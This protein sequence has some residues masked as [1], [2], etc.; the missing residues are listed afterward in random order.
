MLK[1]FDSVLTKLDAE[2]PQE[3]V[4]VH[5]DKNFYSPGETIWFKAYLFAAHAPS[6]ISKTIYAELMDEQGKVIQR[7]TAPVILSGAAAAFDLPV[8]T[9]SSIVFVRVYTRWM[10][11][12][13]SSFLFL[14]A[15]PIVSARKETAKP[16]SASPFVSA[17]FSLKAATWCRG[18]NPG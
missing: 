7:K 2:Y 9:S 15:F 3:K 14:K 16:P 6:L 8:N 17:Y 1:S 18:L 4:Y 11:N 12:F 5:F 10:L 13:D